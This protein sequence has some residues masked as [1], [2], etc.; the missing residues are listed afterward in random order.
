MP[1]PYL[2]CMALGAALNHLPAQVLPAI[3][4]VEG[5]K[6]GTV[7]RNKNGSEDLGVMQVNTLWIPSLAAGTGLDPE[8]VRHELINNACFNIV[9]AGV[10][11]R[12]YLAET[13]G[14]MA[15]AVGNYHSHT[16][17]LNATYQ[18]QVA[19]AAVDQALASAAPA[20]K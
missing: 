5:G 18:L 19:R 15:K 4:H 11:L 1:V 10:I 12:N 6:V 16:P 17:L 20:V 3:H 7:S 13:N 2:A 8:K 9:I 14:D